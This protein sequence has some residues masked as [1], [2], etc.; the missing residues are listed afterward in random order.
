[1]K[2]FID[3]REVEIF[4]S[5]KR[6]NKNTY[7]RVKED[8]NIY[9]TTNYWTKEEAILNLVNNNLDSI[10]KMMNSIQQKKKFNNSFYYLGEKFD[11]IYTNTGDISFIE[12][13]VLINKKLDIDSW[14]NH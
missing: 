10:S 8:L 1:M 5:K 6:K 4:I 12:K 7:L 13:R 9:V 3:N 14:L 11:I 2:I